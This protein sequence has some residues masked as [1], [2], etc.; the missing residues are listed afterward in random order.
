VINISN[1]ETSNYVNGNGCRYVLWVQGCD[2]ACVGCWNQHTWSFEDKILKS[3]DEIFA[4]IQSLEDK[5]DGVTFTGGEPFLQASELSKLSLLIKENT[6][7]DIQIFT[8]FTKEELSENVQIELLKYTDILVAGR[9]DSSKKNNNQTTYILNKNVDNW[10]FNNSDIEIDIDEDGNIKL[11]GYPTN[12][13][14]SE[15]KGTTNA[16]V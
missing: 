13:L 2:L 8:G 6:T 16:R 15:I 5:L 1:I 4:Q 12:K 10:K 14:I 7:L 3:V 11:T 9:Y